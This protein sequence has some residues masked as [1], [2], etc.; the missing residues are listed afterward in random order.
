M[1]QYGWIIEDKTMDFFQ[2]KEKYDCLLANVQPQNSCLA[3]K[4]SWEETK[5]WKGGKKSWKMRGVQLASR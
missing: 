5:V 2:S 4:V 1:E 3:K